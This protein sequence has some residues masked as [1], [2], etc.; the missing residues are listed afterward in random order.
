MVFTR[1]DER[2]EAEYRSLYERAGFKLTRVLP[3]ASVSS[4]LEGK[5][6]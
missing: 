6:L 4:I 3:T 2:S 5:P 1:N